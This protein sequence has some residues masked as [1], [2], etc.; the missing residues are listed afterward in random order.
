LESE[1]SGVRIGFSLYPTCPY[2]VPRAGAGGP[3]HLIS[4]GG[5]VLGDPRYTLETLDAGIVR[6]DSTQ[7]L[8]LGVTRGTAGVRV[9]YLGATGTPDTVFPVQVVVSRVAV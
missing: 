7:R 8:L 6:V 2:R 3:P 4:P 1:P 9:T 5:P